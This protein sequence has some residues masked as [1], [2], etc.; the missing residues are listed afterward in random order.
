MEDKKNVLL[1]AN[2]YP[3]MGG[4]GVQRTAKFVKFLGDFGYKPIVLTRTVEGVLK[5][6]TLMSDLPKHRIYRTKSYDLLNLPGVLKYAG[7]ATNK[8]LLVPDA[9]I[10]WSKYSLNKAIN[11]INT[12]KI[13]LIYSTSFPYSDHLLALKL[14]KIFPEIPWVVDFRD[15]WTANPYILDMNYSARRRK[16]EKNMETCVVNSCDYFITNTPYMLENFIKL[17]PELK[18]KSTV[19]NNGFDSDDFEELDTSYS[20]KDKFTITYVG[21]MYGRRRPDKVFEAISD[22][23]I[24]NKI[25]KDK[26]LLQLIGKMNADE[27]KQITHKFG[28]SENVN[29]VEY[30]PHKEAIANLIDSDVLL[31][32][33]GEGPGA[34]NFSSGKIFEYINCNRPILAVIPTKGAAADIIRE[35]NS[36]V[37]SS[38]SSVN[39]IKNKILALYTDWDK[40]QINYNVNRQAV[41]KYHRRNLTMELAGVFDKLL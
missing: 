25:D 8:F 28:L 29:L 18:S 17:Y 14:K 4:S 35:T 7:K 40:K 2:Q 23:I 9:D 31:L 3:P 36:G 20:Y 34:E 11:I 27:M 37:I 13:D 39:D 21:S 38:N 19:I 22:L 16:V 12:E 15:E 24:S 32:L 26:F 41:N 1:I 30:L 5:D 33:I 10:I 6:E